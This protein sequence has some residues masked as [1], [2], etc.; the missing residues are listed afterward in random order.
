MFCIEFGSLDSDGSMSSISWVKVLSGVSGVVD[1]SIEAT[2]DVT[3]SI[4]GLNMAN[5]SRWASMTNPFVEC[6]CNNMLITANTQTT[7]KLLGDDSIF[8]IF[9]LFNKKDNYDINNSEHPT[10]LQVDGNVII[11]TA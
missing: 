7:P 3:T 9:F 8:A 4:L 10:S 5:R 11:L 2:V 6:H 1:G